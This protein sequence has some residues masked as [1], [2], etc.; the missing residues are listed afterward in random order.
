MNVLN[1]SKKTIIQ[2]LIIVLAIIFI[3]GISICYSIEFT[4]LLIL[5]LGVLFT[6]IL[7]PFPLFLTAFVFLV[8]LTKSLPMINIAGFNFGWGVGDLLLIL[9]FITIFPQFFL[10]KNLGFYEGINNVDKAIIIYFLILLFPLVIAV[11]RYPSKFFFEIAS[12][13]KYF[14][15]FMIYYIARKL[16]CNE[17]K[18]KTLLKTFIFVVIGVIIISF[19]QKLSPKTYLLFWQIASSRSRPL[20]ESF[21]ASVGWRLAGPFFNANSLGRFLLISIFLIWFL[22]IK[23]IKGF[24]ANFYIILIAFCFI[25]LIFTGLRE[26]YIGFLVSILTYLFF[27]K[28]KD[29]FKLKF[30]IPIAFIITI[31]YFNIPYLYHRIVEYTFGYQAG[32]GEMQFGFSGLSRIELWKAAIYSLSRYWLASVGLSQNA[33]ALIDFL[34]TS[35]F[36]LGGGTHNTYL[37]V[38]IEGGIFTFS[39]FLFLLSRIWLLRKCKLYQSWEGFNYVIIASFAGLCVTGLLADTF[40]NTQLM[41]PFFYLL[42]ILVSLNNLGLKRNEL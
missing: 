37:R 30:L 41:I 20:G 42:G 33:N 6:A 26:S 38:F 40:Q 22:Y 21:I 7:F 11:I 18:I 28:K 39:V 3:I 19:I 29:I 17:K 1:N 23:E 27:Y 12:Y 13:V 8:L 24:I 15:I 14:E 9:L 34:P 10:K 32:S 31:F 4:A 2:F 35:S 25:I 5:A 16:I 36:A